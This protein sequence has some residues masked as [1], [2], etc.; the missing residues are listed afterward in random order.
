MKL[1]HI[2]FSDVS[3]SQEREK[4]PVGCKSSEYGKRGQLPLTNILLQTTVM[5]FVNAHKVNIAQVIC[6]LGF[7]CK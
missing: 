3:L 1:F 4:I 5:H 6:L 2:K 7:D